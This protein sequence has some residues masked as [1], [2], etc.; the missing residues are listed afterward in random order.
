VSSRN[1]L[2]QSM[3]DEAMAAAEIH[4]ANRSQL[5]VKRRVVDF[6]YPFLGCIIT[7]NKTQDAFRL[8]NLHSLIACRFVRGH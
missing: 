1:A 6:F 4:A 2:L 5:V 7:T 3:D 8:K